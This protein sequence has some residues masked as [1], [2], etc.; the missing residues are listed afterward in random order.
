MNL[1]KIYTSP[2]R[3]FNFQQ[4]FF[5]DIF[6]PNAYFMSYRSSK[7]K[8]IQQS[9]VTQLVMQLKKTL[10]FKKNMFFFRKKTWPKK[11]NNEKSVFLVLLSFKV[12]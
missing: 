12:I 6:L 3:S 11:K 8:S 5:Y 4:L 1:E 9:I 7:Y 10:V 2:N